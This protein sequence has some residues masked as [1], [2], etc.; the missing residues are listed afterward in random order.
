MMVSLEHVVPDNSE[1]AFL[2]PFRTPT[3]GQ[4][5]VRASPLSTHLELSNE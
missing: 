5:T 1:D 4:H 2:L 3:E